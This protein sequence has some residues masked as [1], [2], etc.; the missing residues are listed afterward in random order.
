M[1]SRLDKLFRTFCIRNIAL[2]FVFVNFAGAIWAWN[3][4]NQAVKE[5]KPF[6]KLCGITRMLSCAAL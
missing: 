1:N 3:Y 6:S 4:S 2:N 5:V